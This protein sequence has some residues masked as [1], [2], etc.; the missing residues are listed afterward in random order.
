M[1]AMPR[2]EPAMNQYPKTPLREKQVT[3]FADDA[4]AGQ[5]HDVDRRMRVEPEHVLEQN[6][7]AADGRVEDADVKAALQ[8]SSASV[9]ATTG[10][11]ST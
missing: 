6:G 7:I 10:V 3:D 8:A 5:N 2:L 1:I 11:P 9:M 4:H